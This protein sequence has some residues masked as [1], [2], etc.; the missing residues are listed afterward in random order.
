MLNQCSFVGNLGRDP[1]TRHTQNGAPVVN[2][3]I[4]VTERWTQGGEKKER[5]EWVPVTIW[6]D[7]LGEIASKFLVKG[8]KVLVQGQWQTRKW[9][10]KE[11]G[12]RYTTECV[13]TKFGGYLELLGG[14]T[15]APAEAPRAVEK[16]IPS[17][18]AGRGTRPAATA[19]LDDDIP[20]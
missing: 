6:N 3:V 4:A 2:F 14:K 10:D 11:G 19:D 1:E 5:T 16:R 17:A 18:P 15:E 7:K 9:V 12:E 20:F 8:S 13:L